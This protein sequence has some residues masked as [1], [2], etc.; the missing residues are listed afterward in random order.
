MRMK[1]GEQI[2]EIPENLIKDYSAMGWFEVK[3]VKET[4]ASKSVKDNEDEE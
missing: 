2:K 3:P 1:K 4:K